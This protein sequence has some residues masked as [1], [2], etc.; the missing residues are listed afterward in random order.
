MRTAPLLAQLAALLL[1]VLAPAPLAAQVFEGTADAIDGDTIAMT[2][3][4]VRLA[5][6]DAP[7]RRQGCESE[8]ELWACG[9][10]AG[11]L[12]AELI[13]GQPVSCRA[14]GRDVYGRE[15]A[16]CRTRDFD[17]GAEMVRRGMAIA[18]GDAP[19]L[20]RTMQSGAKNAARGIWAYDF[21]LPA[22][23]RA[24]NRELLAPAPP[25]SASAAPE[26]SGQAARSQSARVYRNARGC[27]I[28]G[29]RNRR[30]EWIYHLPGRPYYDRTRAEEMFCTEAEAQAAGYRRSRA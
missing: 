26:A 28:K 5:H 18:L 4:R 19:Q 27:A 16:V 23:W 25:A 10:Q 7:E 1:A 30:G 14:S 15:I 22:Q 20:Y 13:G 17:L 2:G 12:L 8:G 9:E 3:T 29:N 11:A 24:A 21:R 6:I